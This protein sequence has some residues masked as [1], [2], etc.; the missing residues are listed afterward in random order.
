MLARRGV[1][2][3][4]YY[5]P[6]DVTALYWHFVD[7]VWIFLLPMLYLLGTHTL[8]DFHISR[9]RAAHG[10]G[11][12]HLRYGPMSI[13]CVLLILLTVLTVTVSFIHLPGVWHI[14]LGLVIG[15]VQGHPGRAVF[16]ARARQL[17]G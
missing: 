16:H 5:S 3:P 13:V 4:A 8:A 14:I 9:R 17:H 15:A 11:T 1:F 2:S 7:M 10:G 12:H 6:V